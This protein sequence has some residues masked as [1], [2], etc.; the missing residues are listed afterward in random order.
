[1]LPS[2]NSKPHAGTRNWTNL[3]P[4][5]HSPDLANPVL[6]RA[7]AGD[8]SSDQPISPGAIVG[9]VIA[10]LVVIA[11]FGWCTWYQ[12]KRTRA[13]QRRRKEH[14]EKRAKRKREI[15]RMTNDTV[16]GLDGSSELNVIVIRP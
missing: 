7:T 5:Q 9:I 10:L 15:L 3:V 1:M 11:A 14:E 13:E 8:P 2:L 12:V 4:L 6:R 16:G